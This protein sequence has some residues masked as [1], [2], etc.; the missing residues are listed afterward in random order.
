MVS[1]HGFSRLT[2]AINVVQAFMEAGL[3]AA[4]DSDDVVVASSDQAVLLHVHNH[5][6]ERVQ[7]LV[8]WLQGQEWTGVIFTR[9]AE[10][11]E[12]RGQAASRDPQGWVDGTFSLEL[13]H[14]ASNERGPDLLF[15][16][17]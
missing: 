4:P 16:F 13:I 15:T 10:T 17:P 8:Q 14:L 7:Q 6:P 11:T 9:G 1:D 12:G 5:A 2:F 3:K